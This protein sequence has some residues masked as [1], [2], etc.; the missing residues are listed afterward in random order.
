AL[1]WKHGPF[2]IPEDIYAE[3]DAREAGARAEQQWNEKFAA[4]QAEFPELAAEF[5]RRMAGELPADFEGK[6]SAFIR[7]V[8]Q[9]GESI[10]SR[11]ASRSCR[12]FLGPLRRELLGGSADLGGSNLT[13]WSGCRRVVAGDASG[14][15]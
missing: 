9:K 4:Y 11:R 2:E 5:K 12:K 15:Y 14:N 7:E 3:W 13:L 1:G 8:A 6:A 10:A